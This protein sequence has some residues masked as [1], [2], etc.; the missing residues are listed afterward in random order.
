MEDADLPAGVPLADVALRTDV[1][2]RLA[3]RVGH[4]AA[5]GRAVSVGVT[6]RRPASRRSWPYHSLDVKSAPEP[7][8]EHRDVTLLPYFA[9]ANRG[10]GAMRVWIP[11]ADLP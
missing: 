11:R 2:P 4:R 7:E 8:A 1:P 5:E 9:W 6:I 3:G 10:E